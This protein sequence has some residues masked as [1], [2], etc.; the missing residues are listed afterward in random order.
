MS[1]RNI[2]L[3]MPEE[4]IERIDKLA[5]ALGR[6]RGWILNQAAKQ[7]IEH[8]EWF[9]NEVEHGLREVKEGKIVSAKKVKA[10]F[11]KWGA[12]VS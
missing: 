10:R 2:S 6:S 3:R 9:V 1:A 11:K 12:D 7:F 4:Q 5:A 8:E